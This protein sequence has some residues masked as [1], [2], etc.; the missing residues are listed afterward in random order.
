M[1]FEMPNI[2]KTMYCLGPR[3]LWQTAPLWGRLRLRGTK[4]NSRPGKSAAALRIVT[5]CCSLILAGLAGGCGRDAWNG[6]DLE[7]ART[8]VSKRDW[9]LAERL[10]ERYLREEQ[11]P[12]KR[13]EAWQQLLEV[14]NFSNVQPRASLEYL[15]AMSEEFADND[16]RNKV[17]LKHTGEL[18]ENLRHYERAADAWSAYIGLAGLSAAETVEAYRH[19]ARMQFSLRRFEAG[20][21]ALQQCLALPLPDHDKIMCM[22]DLADQNMARE[23]WQEVADLSQQILDSEPDKQ[24]RGL[25][26]YLLADALEQLGQKKEALKQFE[27]ARDDYPNSAVIDNRIAHL[28]K[29]LKQ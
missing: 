12:D 16:A 27:L 5:F 29:K 1:V 22:Y 4:N 28:R 6:D 21:E 17:I 13:W 20:E 18:S 9:P 23:R 26:G 2:S 10:L 7:A 3:L 24:V 25:A 19:L 15:E 8:A 11:N 14:I